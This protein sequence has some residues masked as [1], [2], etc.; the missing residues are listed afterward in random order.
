MERTEIL[1]TAE[2]LGKD[3]AQNK[4]QGVELQKAARQ[5]FSDAAGAHY[6]LSMMIAHLIEKD[7]VL[8][9]DA[10]SRF[11]LA[12]KESSRKTIKTNHRSLAR[13]IMKG[14]SWPTNDDGEQIGVQKAVNSARE[15]LAPSNP[16]DA[17]CEMVN[18]ACSLIYR[19]SLMDLDAVRAEYESRVDRAL[20][21][22][23][24][25]DRA[26]IDRVWLALQPVADTVGHD[27]DE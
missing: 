8:F 22:G 27:T 17:G 23:K 21:E 18:E 5:S 2:Q 11:C 16:L 13:A 25:I 19:L 24:L 26:S 7:A 1:K 20:A 9:E 10:L 14:W 12:F 3:A 4:A 15:F 6:A